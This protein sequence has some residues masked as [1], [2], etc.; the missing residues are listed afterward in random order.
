LVIYDL[1]ARLAWANYFE[2]NGIEYR[3]F[4]AALARKIQDDAKAEADELAREVDQREKRVAD[5]LRGD[6][7]ESVL[8]R[9]DSW[10]KISSD[11]ENE[12]DIDDDS[13]E[14]VSDQEVSDQEDEDEEA[15]MAGEAD[16]QKV[17]MLNVDELLDLFMTECPKPLREKGYIWLL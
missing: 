16:R 2:A 3:F 11:I 15:R 7:G 12:L 6:D 13:E 14:D 5:A 1:R 17:K 9:D 8:D 4:S 10:E